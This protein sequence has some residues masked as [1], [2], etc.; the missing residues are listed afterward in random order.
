MTIP[1]LH[2]RRRRSWPGR[3]TTCSF[4]FAS[5][6]VRLTVSKAMKALWIENDSVYV[7]HYRRP[8]L[9]EGWKVDVATSVSDGEQLLRRSAD[10]PYDLLIL[11]VMMPIVSEAEEAAYPSYS[12]NA[13]IETG[14]VLLQRTKHLLATL[15]TAVLV[16]T[17]RLDEDI[18]HRFEREGFPQLSFETK[19][20]LRDTE[21]FLGA[22]NAVVRQ[23]LKPTASALQAGRTR[24]IANGGRV[25]N[26]GSTFISYSWDNDDHRNWVRALAGRLRWRALA[27]LNR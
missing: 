17:I 3:P 6:E 25:S 2:V 14:L 11:D 22:V 1:T 27:S 21:T 12:T 4:P 8:L 19:L 24:G 16:L 9:R 10:E 5:C 20:R 18:R 15:G 23:R 26:A 13:G 7:E